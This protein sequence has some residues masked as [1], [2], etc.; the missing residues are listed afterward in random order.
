MSL[1]DDVKVSHKDISINTSLK[2]DGKASHIDV[3]ELDKL[4]EKEKQDNK[5]AIWIKLDKTERIQR[6]QDYA[7]VYSKEN[8]MNSKEEKALRLFFK[9]CLDK[10]KLNKAKDVNYNKAERIIISIPALH[11]NTVTKNYTLKIMD[12][13]RVST[14]KSLTPKKKSLTNKEELTKEEK[15]SSK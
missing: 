7:H 14:L 9:S 13:K 4:L 11:F 8:K 6:L 15:E 5:G 12:S 1:K 2:D 10:N 3:N